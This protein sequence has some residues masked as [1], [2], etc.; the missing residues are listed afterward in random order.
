MSCHSQK[1][2]KNGGGFGVKK[3]AQHTVGEDLRGERVACEGEEATESPSFPHSSSSPVSYFYACA[4]HISPRYVGKKNRDS[5]K[6]SQGRG[7]SVKRRFTRWQFPSKS[8]PT[9]GGRAPQFGSELT[10]STS[11]IFPDASH[12]T[13]VPYRHSH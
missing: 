2:S 8:L 12:S 5:C 6:S 10:S 11:V 7:R 3:H 4:R 9:R 13:L 1:S